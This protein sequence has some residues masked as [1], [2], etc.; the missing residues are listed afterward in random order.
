MHLNLNH[1]A[2]E[3]S[4]E[5][6]V[7]VQARRLLVVVTTSIHIPR[8]LHELRR[9]HKRKRARSESVHANAALFRRR[10]TP[11]LFF[12]RTTFQGVDPAARCSHAERIPAASAAHTEA[13]SESPIVHTRGRGASPRSWAARTFAFIRWTCFTHFARE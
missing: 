3:V 5:K 2:A 8:G 13:R 11:A 1:D 7:G 6:Q 10:V 4:F 9:R 12:K